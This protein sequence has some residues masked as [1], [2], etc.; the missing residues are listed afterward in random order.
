MDEQQYLS[1]VMRQCNNYYMLM[2]SM[3]IN[4]DR[5]VGVTKEWDK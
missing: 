3:V 2:S 1:K 4:L 5:Y